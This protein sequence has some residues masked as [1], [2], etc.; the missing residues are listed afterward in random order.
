MSVRRFEF[1]DS[2]SYKFWEI[3]VEG[4]SYTVRYGKV[5]TAGVTQTKAFATPEKAAADANKKLNAKVGKGYSEVGSVAV[6]TP[7]SADPEA[8][9]TVRADGLQA[10]GDPWGQRIALSIA[11]DAAKGADKRKW[12][13]ELDQ[14]SADNREHFF[15]AELAALMDQDGFDKVARLTWQYG[16]IVKARVGMPEYGF[17]GPQARAVL[18]AIVGSPAAAYLRDLTIGLYDFEGGGLSGVGSDI[19]S[20]LELAELERLF[21]GDFNSEEQEI[22]W[23][24]FGDISPIYPRTPKLRT[25][26]LQGAGIVL[27][28]LE[29]P[30]LARLE[31]E[32]GGLPQSSVASLAAAKLPELVHMEAWF[33]RT[34]YGGTTDIAA[35]RPIFT[36]QTLPKLKHLGLQNSEMQDAIASEL[37]NSPLLAQVESVDLSMGTMREPG[38]QAILTNAAA[39]KHLKSLNLANNYIPH[40]LTSQLRTALGRAVQTSGQQSA[41]VYDGESYYYTTVGE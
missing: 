33:G 7:K 32:T 34:E 17:D 6:A 19:A 15:G 12:T 39:F 9:W 25:L 8:D 4:C 30:T 24:D 5:G 40:E 21:I 2:R 23:V 27:G 18:R 37:A 26:R 22:S 16:Y 20:G 11:R 10:A 41:D 1:K 3:T 36:S 14:L 31:I 13:K 29:H 38:A 35:L 28:E